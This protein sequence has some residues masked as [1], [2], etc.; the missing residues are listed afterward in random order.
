MT[1]NIFAFCSL[2]ALARCQLDNIPAG[3]NADR[4][5]WISYEDPL[6]AVIPGQFNRTVF[7]APSAA[8]VSDKRVA[9]L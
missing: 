4:W 6:L 5:S 7:D 3:F 1:A 8:N 2:V 9:A